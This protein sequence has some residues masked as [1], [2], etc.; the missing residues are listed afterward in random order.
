VDS[1]YFD[2]AEMDTGVGWESGREK[3]IQNAYVAPLQRVSAVMEG[4]VYAFGDS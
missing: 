3:L 4:D 1:R 2:A